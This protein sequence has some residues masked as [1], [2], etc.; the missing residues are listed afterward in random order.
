MCKMPSVGLEAL[1][2]RIDCAAAPRL[3]M[4]AVILPNV[5]VPGWEKC[6]F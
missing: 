2:C 5:A 1:H 4:Q 3:T 6:R